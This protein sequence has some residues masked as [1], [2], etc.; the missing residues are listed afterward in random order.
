MFEVF[1][2]V[3]QLWPL[4][5]ALDFIIIQSYLFTNKMFDYFQMSRVIFFFMGIV[6]MAAIARASDDLEWTKYIVQSQMGFY[7]IP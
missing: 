5:V 6:A 7:R 4:H 2:H 1:E 3:H